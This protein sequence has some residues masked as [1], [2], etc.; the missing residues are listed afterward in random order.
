MPSSPIF[1]EGL[2][3]K[4]PLEVFHHFNSIDLGNTQDNICIAGEVRIYLHRHINTSQKQSKPALCCI[5]IKNSIHHGT[6][7]EGTGGIALLP[8]LDMG[9]SV[10]RSMSTFDDIHMDHYEEL[11]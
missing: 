9:A 4:R 10:Y 5:M 8:L 3:G 1:A 11:V 6:H 7:M 2:R